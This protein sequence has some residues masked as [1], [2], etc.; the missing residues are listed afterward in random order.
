MDETTRLAFGLNLY[1]LMISYAF[2]KLGIATTSMTRNY[3]FTKIRFNGGG[4]HIFSLNDLENG[5]RRANTRHPYATFP[6][7]A[8]EDPRLP[9]ALS[10]LDCRIHY[11]LNCGAKSCPPVKYFLSKS[12]DE[13]LRV[14]ALSFCEKNETCLVDEAKHELFLSMLMK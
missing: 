11:G 4:G 5:L 13:E 6:P 8:K 1:N 12:V 10:N 9:M 2:V 7:F 3:F 14:V